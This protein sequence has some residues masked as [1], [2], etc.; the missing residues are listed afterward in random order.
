MISL[1]CEHVSLI[2]IKLQVFVDIL[3]SLSVFFQNILIH[4][5]E[6]KTVCKKGYLSNV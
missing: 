4:V 2:F 6:L 3:W 5:K 1:N